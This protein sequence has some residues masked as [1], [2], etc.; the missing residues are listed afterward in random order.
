MCIHCQTRSETLVLFRVIQCCDSILI[1]IRIRIQHFTSI[2]IQIRVS[3]WIRIRIQVLWTS[4]ADPGCLSR[5]PAPDFS[6]SRIQQKWGGKIFK[7]LFNFLPTK[8]E[9]GAYRYDLRE[10]HLRE[11]D[12][13]DCDLREC[14]LREYDRR[15][16]DR[17]EYDRREYD[18]RECDLREYDLPVLVNGQFF[19]TGTEKYLS[20]SSQN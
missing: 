7:I 13:R 18:L 15:E 12:L 5:I 8:Y 3:L 4:V 2:R 19:F 17:R 20:K 11:H 1:S 9:L 14:D 6:P 16:Y 10:Y